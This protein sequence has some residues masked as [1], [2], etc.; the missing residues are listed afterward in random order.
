MSA[1]QLMSYQEAHDK[2]G[3]WSNETLKAIG[4]FDQPKVECKPCKM[5]KS[6]KRPFSKESS[7]EVPSV[8]HTIVTD[9]HMMNEYSIHGNRYIVTF[10][11]RKSRLLRVYFVKRKSDVTEKTKHFI[12]WVYAPRGVSFPK[13]FSL[14]VVES[15]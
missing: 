14:M 13:I 4:A 11:D 5:A 6:T 2:F 15:M 9:V 10:I 12:Q 3:H 1:S 7:T 8:G